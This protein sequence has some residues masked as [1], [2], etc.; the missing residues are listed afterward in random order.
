MKNNRYINNINKTS[1][2]VQLW[3]LSQPN[4]N[5]FL[6]SVAIG[7]ILSDACLYKVGK[8]AY[9]KFEQSKQQYGLIHNLYGLFRKY[10]FMADIGVRFNKNNNIKSFYFKTYSHPTF[11]ELWELFYKDK[12]KSIEKNFIINY[13]D[14]IALSYWIM[15]D[16]SLHK[17]DKILTLHTE[18]FSKD[19]N[20]M[21]S[22]ELNIKFNLHSYIGKSIVKNKIYY[23]IRIPHKDKN[24]KL[25]LTSKYIIK[26]FQYKIDYTLSIKIIQLI[27]LH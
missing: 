8:H 7:M 14:D 24:I 26:D 9:I 3:K 13:V 27:I 5:N 21:I 12:I 25:N 10:T 17:R 18:N 23:M 20:I 11:T 16:G 6:R 15:G 19:I 2:Q 22:N 1:K 4:L